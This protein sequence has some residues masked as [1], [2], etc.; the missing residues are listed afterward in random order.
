MTLRPVTRRAAFFFEA[1]CSKSRC[2]TKVGWPMMFAPCSTMPDSPSGS[3]AP[4]PD[5]QARRRVRGDLRPIARHSRVRSRRRRLGR[6]HRLGSGHRVG[7]GAGRP[8]RPQLRPVP[9]RRGGPGRPGDRVARSD[10]RRR[11]GRDGVPPDRGGVLWSNQH[12]GH[13]RAGVGGHRDRPTL[14]DCR[15]HRRHRVHRLDP[16]SER[17]GGGRHDPRQRRPGCRRRQRP[18]SKD[19]WSGSNRSSGRGASGT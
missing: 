9:D 19:S 10:S 2:Q 4:G 17:L 1:G 16:Q 14:G 12:P 11:T 5:C 18:R 13:D 15:R 8:A 6:D 7:A 3:R